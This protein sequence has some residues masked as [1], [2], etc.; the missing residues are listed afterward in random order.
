MNSLNEM[1]SRERLT[2]YVPERLEHGVALVVGA[3]ALGQNV[4]LDLA[5]AGVGEIRIV[6]Q[7]L[8]ESHNR[9]R[10]PLFPLPTEQE[11]FGSRKAAAAA[12]KLRPLMTAPRPVVRYAHNW[13]QTLGDGA[14]TDVSVVLS[15]VDRPSARAYLADK[16]RLHCITLIEG[17]FRGADVTVS[18]YPGVRGDEARTAPCWRCSHQDTGVEEG[19]FSCRAYAV[20]AKESGIVPAIQNAAATLAGLQ[21]EAAILSLHDPN[22]SPL[23]FHAIDLNIRTGESRVIKLSTDP[24]CP[25]IHHGLE[26][27]P[28]RLTTTAVDSGEEL[29]RELSSIL[30]R[31]EVRVEL[32]PPLISAANC[33]KCGR[34]TAASCRAW[35]WAMDGRCRECGGPFPLSPENEG[36]TPQIVYYLD[37]ATDKEILSASCAELGFPPLAFVSPEGVDHRSQVFQLGGSVDHLY[38]LGESYG[39]Q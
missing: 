37:L 36:D 7:D 3:G 21:A 5:L 11:R 31:G 38:E 26:T 4:A 8:F 13:I 28:V 35:E 27:P 30:G 29:L 32:D 22:P 9:T 12:K 10:S 34:M 18:C 19:L 24:K 2:G 17:G 23:R 39:E 33:R 6:D 16:A 25:G 20:R 1:F 15:C 14:F